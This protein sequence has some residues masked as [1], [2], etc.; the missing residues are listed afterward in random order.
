M[1]P[2]LLLVVPVLLPVLS[3]LLVGFA[4]PLRT[5]TAQRVFLIGVLVLNAA[6]G[7]AVI[8]RGDMSLEIF[9]LTEALPIMLKTDSLARLFCA[10][11]SVV[12]LLVGIYCPVYIRHEG[13]GSRFYMFFLFVLGAVMGFGLSGNFITLYL[14][15][16]MATLLS[17]PLVLHSMTKEAISAAFKYV[18]FSIAG[19]ALSLI[20]IF[21]IFT[22]GTTLEFTPG[23]VLDMQRLAGS[24]GQ[25][26]FVTLLAIIGF[27]AKAGMFPLHAWLPIAH[28]VAPAPAS[29]IL[30]G[31]ITKVGIFAVI[32]FVYYLVGPEF[33]RGTWVQTAWISLALFTGIMGSLFAFKEQALKRRLA[34]STIS[35]IGYIMFGLAI[36][37]A[38]GLVGA[39]LQVVFHSTAKNAVF[40]VAGA[41]IINTH[42]TKVA[43][44]RGIGRQMPGSIWGFALASLSLVGIPPM[45]GF[46][47]KWF[48]AVG[49]LGA[50]TGFFTWLGPAV[51]LFSALLAAGYLM[52]IVVN[53]FFPGAGHDTAGGKCEAH[54][55]ML[56]PILLFSAA[57]LIL[58]IFPSGL[59]S[60]FEQIASVLL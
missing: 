17:M 57:A 6:A 26:L 35:Q 10:L 41:I 5:E 45:A 19:A 18:Y 50:D 52:P 42:S 58:G 9:R 29:A 30:S 25:M 15:F 39:L 53:G 3:G 56:L 55:S 28:P 4:R 51:L 40:L 27:G 24:E 46:T 54:I 49:S 7:L 23:G 14:F 31:L 1:N 37:T 2:S 33:I 12:F 47:G 11:A 44:M 22:Y 34:Y 20:G 60:F 48:L 8:F 13:S 38:S 16:E 21:F 36:L 32:R 59:I 43:D